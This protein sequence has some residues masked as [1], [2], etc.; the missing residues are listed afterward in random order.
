M[1][2]NHEQNWV[3]IKT[4][5]GFI[6]VPVKPGQ[7]IF[8]RQ[9]A[10]KELK[11]KPSSVRNRM[12]KL[13]SMQNLDIQ[14]DSQYS[15]VSICNWDIYQPD[16]NKTGQSTGQP[17]DS[18]RTAKGQPKDTEKNDKNYKNVKKK[19]ELA[20]SEP[21]SEQIFISFP[22]IDKSDFHVTKTHVKEFQ[23][24]YP[25]VD[26]KQELRNIRGWNISTP[27]KRKTRNG[28]MRHINTWLAKAQNKSGGN[29]AGGWN[30]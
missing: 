8:G 21:H 18:Q 5:K 17:E 20:Q 15:I 9:S 23:E 7:F 16:K 27:K 29:S 14:Q 30:T 26:V 28:A 25:A 19:K 13:K 22:L 12:E 4:G 10:A 2:A 24:L 11:M 3:P 1:R 6:E